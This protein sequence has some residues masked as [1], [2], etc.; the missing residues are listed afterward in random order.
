MII[1][2]YNILVDAPVGL[3]I[4]KH[5]RWW[6]YNGREHLPNGAGF[7]PCTGFLQSLIVASPGQPEARSE[8]RRRGETARCL[9]IHKDLSKMEVYSWE[10]HP[11]LCFFFQKARFDS[12]LSPGYL[13]V[14]LSHEAS[15]YPIHLPL[16]HYWVLCNSNSSTAAWSEVMMP[17]V[18]KPSE[19]EVVVHGY[20]Y[21]VYI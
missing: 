18:G 19:A 6:D 11:F 16:N 9:R 3:T 1:I 13:L 7:L 5:C 10:S 20:V 17:T 12:W 14:F 8:E 15:I 4:L 21:C 2:T